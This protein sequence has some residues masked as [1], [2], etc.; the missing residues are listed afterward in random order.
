MFELNIFIAYARE[1]ESLRIRLDKHLAALRRNSK[2]ITWCDAK[3]EPG[4]EWEKSIFTALSKARIILLLISADFIDSNYCYDIEMKNAIERHESGTAIVIPIIL[5]HCDWLDTPFAKLQV[6]PK[7]AV[8]VMDRKWYNEDEALQDVAIRI[9]TVVQREIADR[10]TQIKGYFEEIASLEDT[11]SKLRLNVAN[12]KKNQRELELKKKKESAG[13]LRASLKEKDLTIQNLE[14]TILELKNELNKYE[15]NYTTNIAPLTRPRAE[16]INSN[17]IFSTIN[18]RDGEIWINDAVKCE[19]G[20]SEWRK[21]GFEPKN[22]MIGEIID[23]FTH[24]NKYCLIYVIFIDDKYYV[25]I[26]ANGIK[27]LPGKI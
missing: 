12:L 21:T 4:K 23:S 20:I 1:D 15:K 10:E 6:L 7:D 17:E 25:P 2:A 26:A 27:I 16:I 22:G 3:I 9:K 18:Q 24:L 13:K 5:S 19:A 14:I 8:P 11:I